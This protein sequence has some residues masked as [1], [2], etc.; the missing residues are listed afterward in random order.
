[1]ED[2]AFLLRCVRADHVL[3][4]A[5][6]TSGW[7]TAKLGDWSEWQEVFDSAA[8]KLETDLDGFY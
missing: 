5:L 2:L 8:V 4:Y 3:A 6:K 1:M 7:T